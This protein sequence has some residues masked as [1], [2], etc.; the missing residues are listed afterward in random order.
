M[1]YIQPLKQSVDM[2]CAIL[3]MFRHKKKL[4]L[5]SVCLALVPDE[6]GQGLVERIQIEAIVLGL[7][8]GPGE[9]VR[10]VVTQGVLKHHR[11]GTGK[12]IV[13]LMIVALRRILLKIV[14]LLLRKNSRTLKRYNLV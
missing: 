7:I 8:Y 14:F 4:N 2:P 12:G 11:P 6:L 13:K 9:K 10:P 5:R 1:G 3:V